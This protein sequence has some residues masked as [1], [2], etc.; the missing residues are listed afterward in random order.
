MHMDVCHNCAN[1]TSPF[2]VCAVKVGK[3]CIV[4]IF[5]LQ[6][7]DETILKK[8][9]FTDLFSH[10]DLQ[11][12]LFTHVYFRTSCLKCKTCKNKYGANMSNSTVT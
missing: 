5:T 6:T 1:V 10:I 2:L 12:K 4:K 3:F 9:I 7:F 11:L 8:Y